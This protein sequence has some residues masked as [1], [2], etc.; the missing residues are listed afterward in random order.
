[1]SY[2]GSLADVF[3]VAGTYAGRVLKGEKPANMPVQ[4]VSKFELFI[5]LSTAK[6]LG[7]EIPDKM[8][9]LA[10]EVIE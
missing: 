4:Q 1:M 10:D 9:A 2:G 7:L 3:R 8:L 5:N 6:A